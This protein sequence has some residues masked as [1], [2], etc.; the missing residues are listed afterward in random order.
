MSDCNLT[1]EK[2]ENKCYWICQ[3]QDCDTWFGLRK[4]VTAFSSLNYNSFFPLFS[5][6]HGGGGFFFS[7]SLHQS[8][9]QKIQRE[10]EKKPQTKKSLL[11]FLFLLV[12]YYFSHP[13][14]KCLPLYSSFLWSETFLITVVESVKEKTKNVATLKKMKGKE[15]TLS[16]YLT[17]VSSIYIWILQHSSRGKMR[18]HGWQLPY[19]PL[20]VL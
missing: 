17:W 7:R 20:Q 5:L 14:V 4:K 9:E 10:S 3:Q 2:E 15:A 11:F 19:H 8:F 18:K 16:V 6:F 1:K 13:V 12:I